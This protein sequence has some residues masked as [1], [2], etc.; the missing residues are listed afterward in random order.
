MPFCHNLYI[1]GRIHTLN[2]DNDINDAMLV[3]CGR[4][5]WTGRQ[6][7]S[8][9][10][11]RWYTRVVD[12]DGRTVVPGFV[13]AHSHFPLPGLSKVAVDLNPPFVGSTDSL[14]GLYQR[15][16]Q[17]TKLN[18]AGQ[19]VF[20][21]N[22]DNTVFKDGKHPDRKSL[23]AVSTEHPIFVR[24][25]SG[26]M[27]V[28]NSAGLAALGIDENATTVSNPYIGKYEGTDE[29]NGL[30]QEDAAPSLVRFIRALSWPQRWRFYR[31]A[32][33]QYSASGFTTVQAGGVTPTNARRLAWLSRLRILPLRLVYWIN[34][35]SS[36][37]TLSDHE[38]STGAFAFGDS[39][40]THGSYVHPAAVKLFADGSPQGF[41]AYLSQP[42][43]TLAPGRADSEGS[44]LYRGYPTYPAE[45]WAEFIE[46]YW[47]RQLP[48]AIHTNGDAAIA[49]VLNGIVEVRQERPA[50]AAQ[51]VT[52]IH[53][54]TMRR[55]QAE[56]AAE[57]GVG[58][59]FFISH[60]FY[61]GDW[62]Q[63]RSLGPERALNI[64]PLQW[65]ESAGLRYSLHSDA[66]VTP[67]SALN[68]LW[69]ATSRQTSSGHVLGAHQRVSRLSAL[70]A[71]TIE[72]AKQAGLD[73][74]RGSLEVG[75]AADFV[76]LSDDPFTVDD[77]RT[78]QVL[79]TVVG[80]RRVYA[81]P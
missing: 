6:R 39:L 36:G 74:H 76:V 21:F 45:Q 52:L 77:V 35:D 44:A 61:W 1:N 13:D 20:G 51:P 41:T 40:P 81:R 23:D 4:I 42:Y 12:L 47:R 37:Y 33:N 15:L 75:K 59:S 9:Q 57:L 72:A 11:R 68:L 49:D 55:D 58:V 56:L 34:H 79:E 53:A 70:R 64:S 60:T 24:H 25:N 63:L 29:L 5:E 10:F 48:L 2:A 69:S 78:L 46:H 67:S 7:D 43:H 28:A 18:K 22:Y 62:H 26:H 32:V 54:Q 71:L 31:S 80:G 16:E 50:L 17:Q 65:A 8:E 14:P 19:W 38:T 66:P 27:G 73:Q 30:L 3:S